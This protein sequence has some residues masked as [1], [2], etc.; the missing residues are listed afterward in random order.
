MIKPIGGQMGECI[1]A[2]AMLGY[3]WPLIDNG[4]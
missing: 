1:Q 4:S 3:R 2:P